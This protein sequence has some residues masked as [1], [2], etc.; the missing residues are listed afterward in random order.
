VSKLYH[1]SA[2]GTVQLSCGDTKPIELKPRAKTVTM[3]IRTNLPECDI[4]LNNSPT[5]VGKSDAQGRFAYQVVPSLFLVEARKKGHLSQMQ[6]INVAPE[7][8]AREVSIILEPIKATLTLKTN[9]DGARVRVD[10]ET[11]LQ[12][13]GER[14]SLSPGPHWLAVEAL[15]H[16]PATFEVNLSADEKLAKSL[17]LRR[18]PVAELAS[19]AES[20]YTRR[21][22]ADVHT[23]CK[24]I[25]EIDG[26][27]PTAHRL[28]G[29][30][31]LAE[32]D[33][34]RAVPHLEKALA[35]DETIRLRVRRHV[36]ENF[37]LNKGHDSCEA[38]LILNKSGVEFQG[39]R[40]ADENF[41]VA[42]AQI[43][44]AGVQLKKNVALYLATKVTVVRGKTRDY[45]LYAFDKELSQSG[46]AYL[47]TLQRL[48]RQH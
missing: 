26:N 43:A 17:T 20:F 6:R 41:K 45:N 48:L 14:V 2:R 47:G 33:Y 35:A 22:Y 27:H 24:Y 12:P 18:L 32:Q 36:R 3:R 8:E 31:Y 39:L 21:A 9:V 10:N 13:A 25:F 1:E 29:L 23:L 28:D 11:E 4:Y 19:Q 30:T 34:P 16:T 40:D 44:V 38:V 42:Y 15:G 7:G 46:K 37:D 5:S